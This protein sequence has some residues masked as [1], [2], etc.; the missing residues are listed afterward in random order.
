MATH[1][2]WV[3]GYVDET[4]WSRFEQPNLSSWMSGPDR[5][6]LVEH[7]PKA[8]EEQKALASYGLLMQNCPQ[9]PGE[10]QEQVWLRFCEGHPI[11]EMSI[12]FLEWC[13]GKLEAQAKRVWVLVWDNASWHISRMVMAWI[14]EHNRQVK[15]SGKGVRIWVC[16]L[17]TQSPWLNPIEPHWVHGKR[18]VVAPNSV[19]SP[20][21]LERRVYQALACA[22]EPHLVPS[23]NVV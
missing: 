7:L 15:T 11:S 3:V 16:P 10:W 8:K 1:P 17:P 21:E 6:H 5:L 20:Q 23:K 9:Q 18:R 13:C 19:L 14:R 22:P 2:E 4:W 12:Q